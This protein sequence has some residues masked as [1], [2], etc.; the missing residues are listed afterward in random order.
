[1][2][3]LIYAGT[4]QIGLDPVEL[5]YKYTV[6]SLLCCKLDKINHHL[7]IFEINAH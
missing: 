1:M 4:F 5:W 2:E 3:A 6:I 7:N